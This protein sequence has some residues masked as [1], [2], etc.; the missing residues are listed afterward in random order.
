MKK[1]G[2]AKGSAG[3]MTDNYMQALA[4]LYFMYPSVGQI[5]WTL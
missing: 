3:G 4:M 2:F 5:I 1:E